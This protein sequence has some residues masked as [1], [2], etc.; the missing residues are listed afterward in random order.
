VES[1]AGESIGAAISRAPGGSTA[2]GNTAV[3]VADE[4]LETP[5]AGL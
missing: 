3:T 1:V 2:G 5:D 4:R